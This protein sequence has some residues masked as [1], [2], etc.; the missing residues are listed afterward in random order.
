MN[1]LADAGRPPLSVVIPVRNEA[2][3]LPPLLADLA[4][5]PRLVRQVLVV[6]GGSR[7]AT[8]LVARL[9]GARVLNSPAGRG[10]QLRRGLQACDGPWLL[11]L[12]GDVRL[13]AGWPALME[14]AIGGGEGR[15]WAFH[16]AIEGR[17]PALRL[18]ERAVSLR[19]RWRG[20][21]YGDQGLL[22]SRSLHDRVGGLRPLPL[23]EDLDFA[24]RL[25][26]HG[27][28]G[29]LPAALRVSDRRW[30]RLGVWQTVLANARLR[31]DWRQGVA[32]AELARRYERSGRTPADGTG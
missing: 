16:L 17:D 12:H 6:D 10:E 3:G 9:G 5:A 28:P 29:L 7:D 21:P 13:P 26:R 22:I 15:A 4:A 25:R 27:R 20:L 11:L 30:R 24:L 23:M 32:P 8:A 18:V 31:R 19:S 14:R 2:R 1:A